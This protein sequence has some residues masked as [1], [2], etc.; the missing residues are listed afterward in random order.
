MRAEWRNPWRSFPAGDDA[1]AIDRVQF[2]Q[3]GAAAGSV[4]GD[5]RG[6]GTAEQVEDDIAVARIR[7]AS[8]GGSRP[9]VHRRRQ[10]PDVGR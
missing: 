4:R 7:D 9:P 1:V 8:C 6:A 2:V 3:E 10:E 5:Q